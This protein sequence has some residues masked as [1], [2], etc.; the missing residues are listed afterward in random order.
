[1][2]LIYIKKKVMIFDI[3]IKYNMIDLYMLK[4][5]IITL[6]IGEMNLAK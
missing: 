6:S 4:H 5:F 2:L 1:M 3:F